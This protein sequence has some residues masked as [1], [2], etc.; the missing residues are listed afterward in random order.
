MEIRIGLS[1][2]QR[3]AIAGQ[4]SKLLADS[5]MLYLKTH[6]FHW[7]VTG[8]HFAELHTLFEKQYTELS[9]A[10]DEIA[11]RIRALGEYAPGSFAQFKELTAIEEE[12]GHPNAKEMIAQLI[13]AQ[14]QV[15]RTARHAMP[16]AEDAKDAPTADLL[17]ERMNVHE[18]NAWMLRSLLEVE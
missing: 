9:A 14:E 5:Y 8:P 3:S 7:N 1:D 15:V 10:I 6:N 11:E 17:T 4:L 12:T 16:I 18:K 13:S 2:E